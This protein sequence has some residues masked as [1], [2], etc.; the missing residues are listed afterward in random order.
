MPGDLIFY[1]YKKNGRY[2]N[3]S[4]VAMVAE[5]GMMVHASSSKKMVVMTGLSLDRVVA[6]CR[7][8]PDVVPAVPEESQEE[9][10]VDTDLILEWSGN[11]EEENLPENQETQDAGAA[12]VQESMEGQEN[13][14]VLE[15]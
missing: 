13:I 11:Q 5:N 10:V 1:S 14:E 8:L 2:K 15:D 7:P 4:H 12:D 3:I 6:I 9:T